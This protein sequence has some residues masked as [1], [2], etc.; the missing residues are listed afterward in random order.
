MR[1]AGL[2]SARLVQVA[3][4]PHR[5]NQRFWV[6]EH[7]LV[8]QTEKLSAG[9]AIRRV[10]LNR[11]HLVRVLERG[12]RFPSL[13]I[14]R[15]GDEDVTVPEA[16]RLAIP[17]RHV[18]AEPRDGALHVELATDVDVGHE[19]ARDARHDLHELRRHDD[20]VLA[21]RGRMPPPQEAFGPAILRRPVR[22][23]GVALMIVLLHRPRLVLRREQRHHGRD[24]DLRHEE[25]GIVSLR[26]AARS[27][28]STRREPSRRCA[29]SGRRVTSP[30]PSAP[31]S[32]PAPS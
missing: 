18:G 1:I 21:H 13:D 31:R 19:V 17:A 3:D 25:P 10:D 9:I 32:A 23:V 7:R 20:L 22:D 2:G 27:G 29:A 26:A 30:P 12:V 24:L 16:D 6:V 28:P 8:Y 11:L 14:G 4:D 5:L 15:P